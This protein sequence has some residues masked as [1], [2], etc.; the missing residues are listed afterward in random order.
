MAMILC[1]LQSAARRWGEAIAIDGQAQ[2][3]NYAQL[4]SRVTGLC[5][6]L[7]KQQVQNGDHVG[8]CGANQI[9]AIVLMYACFRLGAVFIPLSTRFPPEQQQQLIDQLNIKFIF[10]DHSTFN[11]VKPLTILENEGERLWQ[12]DTDLPATMVLTSGSSGTP[13]AAVHS[14]LQQLA[15]AEGS[16]DQTPLVAGDRWLLSLPMYHIGGLAILFRCLLSGATAVLP[17]NKAAEACLQPQQITHVSMVATQ[18]QRLIAKDDATS[19]LG[20][21]KVILLGGGAIPTRLA[22]QLAQFPLRALT[23]YGMT[24]MGSQ[25]TTGPANIQGLAGF[26]LAGRQ[27]E[28][29]DGIIHVKGEC[30]FMGYYLNGK[31]EAATDAEGWFATRDRGQWISEQLK[32]LGRADNMFISGGE[33]VQPEAIEAV[34][35]RCEG[36]EQVIVAPVDD[37][38]FGQLPV[39]IIK[40]DYDQATV[41]KRL[42]KKL[43]RFM[44]PRRFLAWPSDHS[45]NGIKVNRQA[46]IRYA[47]QHQ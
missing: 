29:I 40:G 23:S 35:S 43:A 41:E 1:P 17:D 8:Y 24:E 39:A 30:L 14:L 31:I 10:A 11:N 9:E 32:I 26:P 12:L 18:A 15:A 4:D 16:F 34:I 42:N 22:E 33:N 25:I 47:Q 44:R 7:R 2:Q 37:S 46:L 27:I 28:I 13:K 6:D 36:V 5:N 3:L 38:E 21:V 45:S 20:T 19:I